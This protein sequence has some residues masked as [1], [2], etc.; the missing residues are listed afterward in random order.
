ME[1]VVLH[2]LGTGLS[3]TVYRPRTA[4]W[5]FCGLVNVV[6]RPCLLRHGPDAEKLGM[7][8]PSK[9]SITINGLQAIRNFLLLCTADMAF[10]YGI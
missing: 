8:R 1:E 7:L 2:I 9:I 5:L 10:C 6:R 3:V 4:S